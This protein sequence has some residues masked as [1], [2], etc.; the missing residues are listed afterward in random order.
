METFLVPASEYM[1]SPVLT[2]PSDASTVEAERLLEERDVTAVGV[3]D[4]QGLIGVLSRSDLLAAAS[5]ELGEAF[6]LPDLPVVSLM[7]PDPVRVAAETPLV[8][9]AA[10]MLEDGFHRVFVEREGEVV[11]V[12]SARDIMRAVADARVEGSVDSIASRKVDTISAVDPIAFAVERLHETTRHGLVVMDEGY[13]VG[14]FSQLDALLC[15][16]RDPRT[17]VEE[18]MDLRLLVV[19]AHTALHRAAGQALAMGVRRFVLKHQGAM[20]GI[21]SPLDFCHV[22]VEGD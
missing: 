9:V 13:P 14:T 18:A 20:V 16:A 22:L 17:K 21:V 8:E 1:S 2:V 6:S 7:T 19:P 15:R 10:L 11:G 12:V 4:G 5:G 3:A